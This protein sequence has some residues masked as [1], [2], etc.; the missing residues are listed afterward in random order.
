MDL[1][2]LKAIIDWMAQTPLGELEIAEGDFRVHLVKTAT[3]IEPAPGEEV[4]AAG[5][6]V[7]AASFGV[8]HLSPAPDAEPFVQIGQRVEAGQ[9]LCV[10]E[11]MKVFSPIEA[12]VAGTVTA[13][14]VADGADVSAGQPLFRLE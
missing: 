2:R 7:T 11:A 13:I 3:G 12:E 8:I 5:Q 10:I 4:V 14:L 1:D 6:I 9:S